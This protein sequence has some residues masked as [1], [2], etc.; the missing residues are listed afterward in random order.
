MG[1]L[2]SYDD[3]GWWDADGIEPSIRGGDESSRSRI[4]KRVRMNN[5]S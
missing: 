5:L 3:V 1:R 2:E 4:D